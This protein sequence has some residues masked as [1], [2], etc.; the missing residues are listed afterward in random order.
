ML[1]YDRVTAFDGSGPQPSIPW[2]FV[3]DRTSRQHT[4]ANLLCAEVASLSLSVIAADVGSQSAHDAVVLAVAPLSV[5][6]DDG[7]TS[8]T[9]SF[10][11]KI[12]YA[13][14]TETAGHQTKLAV[15]SSTCPES[16]L[17]DAMDQP[18]APDFD[19]A[20]AGANDSIVVEGGKS[21]AAVLPLTFK[22]ADFASPS[23]KAPARRRLTLTATKINAGAVIDPSPTNNRV[24]VDL[25]IVDNNDF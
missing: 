5:S 18:I 16:V 4:E 12:F 8:E 24:R 9:T 22:A 6:I 23:S 15:T 2:P 25:K 3:F 19:K 11:V 13:D 20:T 14:L 10:K 21:V 1:S 7:A 17:L